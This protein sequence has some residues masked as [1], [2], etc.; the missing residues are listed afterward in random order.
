MEPSDAARSSAPHDSAATLSQSVNEGKLRILLGVSVVMRIRF[1]DFFG[2]ASC[3][4][5]FVI[6]SSSFRVPGKLKL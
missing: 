3:V 2:S 6:S 4:S 5:H 1:T